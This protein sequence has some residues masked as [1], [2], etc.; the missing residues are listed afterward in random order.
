MAAPRLF[1]FRSRIWVNALV[2]IALVIVAAYLDPL[3]ALIAIAGFRFTRA[4]DRNYRVW[5][6]Q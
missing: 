2:G 4:A 6:K 3:V 1:G 5:G